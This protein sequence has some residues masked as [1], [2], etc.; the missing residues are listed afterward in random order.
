MLI[1]CCGVFGLLG[2]TLPGPAPKAASKKEDP[3][4]P[5][6]AV[7]RKYLKAH[8]G[9]VEVTSWGSRTIT[10]NTVLGGHAS[11]AVYFRCKGESKIQ[12]GFFI[13]GPGDLVE[14][15]TISD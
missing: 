4:S 9:E 14:S 7:I 12:Y 13:I 5:D 3:Y 15:A 11:L 6:C 1:A 8:Y 2:S 10:D